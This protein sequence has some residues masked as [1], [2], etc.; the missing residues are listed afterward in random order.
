MATVLVTGG[1]GYVGS[2]ACKALAASGHEPVVFDNLSTGWR[3]AV[4]WGPLIEGDLKDRAAVEA[5]FREYAPEAVMHFA[6]LSHVGESVIRPDLYWQDNVGGTMNLAC[7]AREAGVKAFVFSST[8]ATYGEVRTETLDETHPQRPINPYGATKLAMEQMLADFETGFDMRSV[9]FR[10]FNAAGADPDREIGENRHPKAH[11]IPIVLEA[12]SGR[13]GAL[14]IHGTDYPTPDGTCIRDYIHVSDLA[15]AHVLG[16]DW[17]LS[18]GESLALNL[19]S[20]TGHSVRAVL[21]T[22]ARVTGCEI[23]VIEGPRRAGDPVRLVSGSE[24]AG[25]TLGWKPARSALETI[26]D[27]AWGWHQK[28]GHRG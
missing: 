10:Y 4:R 6:A 20:G 25:K 9:I 19:G 21:D 12:A 14:T 26:I 16:L 24:L 17:L 5:A 8:C 3:D 11:L 15:A 28:A 27:D 2:H 7:A 18:G 1:A 22:A 13:S 23:P